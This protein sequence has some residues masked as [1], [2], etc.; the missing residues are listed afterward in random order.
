MEKPD[1]KPGDWLRLQWDELPVVAGS[2]RRMGRG[3]QVWVDE[4]WI[5]REGDHIEVGFQWVNVKTIREIRRVAHFK[6]R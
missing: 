6:A 1:I 4:P 3:W 2:L 5:S